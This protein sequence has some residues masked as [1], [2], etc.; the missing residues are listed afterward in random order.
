MNF[1]STNFKSNLTQAEKTALKELKSNE[2]II[3]IKAD[4]EGEIVII[5][6]HYIE[7]VNKLIDDDCY[8]QSVS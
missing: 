7:G 2:N 8:M 4:K 6:K 3:I 1:T 5:D